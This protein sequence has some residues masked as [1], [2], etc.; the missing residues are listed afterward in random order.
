MEKYQGGSFTTKQASEDLNRNLL[1]ISRRFTVLCGQ[2]MLQKEGGKYCLSKEV[3]T[4]FERD[5]NGV[6]REAAEKA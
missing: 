6:F 3:Y 1:S 5:E 4:I 2:G